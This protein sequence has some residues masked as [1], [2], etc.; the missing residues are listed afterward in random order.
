MTNTVKDCPKIYRG[1]G[2]VV[3]VLNYKTYTIDKTHMNY[4]KVV[5]ALKNPETPIEEIETLVNLPKF[6]EL[7]S[8]GNV[9]IVKDDGE[10]KVYYKNEIMH[11]S[12]TRRLIAIIQEGY[13]IAAL[14]AFLD[15]LLLNPSRTS[16]Q[17]LYEFLEKNNLPITSD[18]CFLAYKKVRDDY[19]DF[20]TGTMSNTV[21][22]VVS[23]IRNSVDDNRENTCSDGLHFCS[24]DYL[25]NYHGG[26]G[27]IM[28]VKINPKDV[29]SFPRDYN[30][31]KGRTCEYLVVG[32]HTDGERKEAFTKPIEDVNQ[33]DVNEDEE[34]SSSEEISEE[35]SS[36]DDTDTEY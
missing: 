25:P 32:E 9:R 12:L 14:S 35:S 4:S 31:S 1:D 13:D 16:V 23:M 8:C 15:N 11:N 34:L 5:A 33:Y 10:Y 20:Y 27:R 19:L 28:I 30:H 29:V 36:S 24:L 2:T 6:V 18:G 3:I 21:G 7:G 26:D 22:T 17:E